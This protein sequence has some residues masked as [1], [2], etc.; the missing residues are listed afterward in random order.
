MECYYNK[1]TFINNY[2]LYFNYL[3]YTHQS[4]EC[5]SGQYISDQTLF[6]SN[7]VICF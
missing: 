5:R 4:L 6:S 1:K 7:N 3:D 2:K